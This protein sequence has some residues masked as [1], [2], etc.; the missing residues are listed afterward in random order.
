MA[1][2]KARSTIFGQQRDKRTS[3]GYRCRLSLL[4]LLLVSP[5]KLRQVFS[6]PVSFDFTKRLAKR[7]KKAGIVGKYG[8]RYGASFRKIKKM[9][10]SQHS[11]YLCEFCGN[12]HLFDHVANYINWCLEFLSIQTLKITLEK[13]N[14]DGDGSTSGL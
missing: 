7:T 11:K 12:V 4:P 2:S 9:E 14:D 10:V 6:N 13:R 5:V 1:T 3:S 8:T